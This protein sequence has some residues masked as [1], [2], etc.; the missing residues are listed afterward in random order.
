M[1]VAFDILDKD[2]DVAI[3]SDE[4]R[5]L[6]LETTNLRDIWDLAT[7][8]WPL[9]YYYSSCLLSSCVCR[10]QQKARAKQK[11]ELSDVGYEVLR[12]C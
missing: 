1:D 7:E 11:N 2:K 6:Q 10:N 4:I 5:G 12:K 3:T 9:K 8:S